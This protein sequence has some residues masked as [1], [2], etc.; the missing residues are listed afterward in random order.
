MI[1]FRREL[2][3]PRMASGL[4]TATVNDSQ[5]LWLFSWSQY[6]TIV[7]AMKYGTQVITNEPVVKNTIL[8]AFHLLGWRFDGVV[9]STAFS[10]DDGLNLQQKHLRV[11]LVCSRNG[12]VDSCSRIW[13][14]FGALPL[15]YR[16][17]F[18]VS[19]PLGPLVAFLNS[20]TFFN[21]W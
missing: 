16:K 10:S 4:A 14:K 6:T 15:K 1:G 12:V 20:L 13:L 7:E 3:K 19:V 17:L 21:A 8:I 11:F 18:A 2:E 9:E 5:K